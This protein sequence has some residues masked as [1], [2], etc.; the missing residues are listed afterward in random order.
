MEMKWSDN[1]QLAIVWRGPGWYASR[2]EGAHERQHVC[3]YPV[4]D[5]PNEAP[6][7]YTMGLGTPIWYDVPAEAL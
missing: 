3:A 4:G 1:G 5:N 6:D 7:V 2:Q